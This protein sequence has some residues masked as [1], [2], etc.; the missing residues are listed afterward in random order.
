MIIENE[1]KEKKR[2]EF[3]NLLRI[4]KEA[5]EAFKLN[6]AE[7]DE[8]VKDPQEMMLFIQKTFR[9]KFDAIAA[10]LNQSNLT[11]QQLDEIYSED[12][13][14]LKEYVSNCNYAMTSFDRFT[15]KEQLEKLDKQM[16]EI[17][18]KLAPPKKFAFSK[19]N[20]KKEEPAQANEVNKAGVQIPTGNFGEIGGVENKSGEVVR[21]TQDQLTTTMKLV[22]L[23][24]CEIYLEGHLGT[25][26]IKEVQKCK[27]YTGPIRGSAFVDTVNGCDIQLCAQQIRIHNTHSTDFRTYVISDIIIEDCKDLHFAKY[28]WSYANLAQDME[29]TTFKEKQ[30]NWNVVKDFN[31]LKQEASPHF[32]IAKKSG[33]NLA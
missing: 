31:W 3:E 32:R 19:K 8:K 16:T 22:N 14:L 20:F 1:D 7:N 30:N 17:R 21:L 13:N 11:L 6:K 2:L 18:N 9:E 29:I 12:Y 33:D 10:K 27:I 15:Y 28:N 23:K 24:D 25:L 26:Y 4:Q 5:R